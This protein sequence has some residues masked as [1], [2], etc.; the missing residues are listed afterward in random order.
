ML[1]HGQNSAY[2]TAFFILS[3]VSF[4]LGNSISGLPRSA[5]TIIAQRKCY[6]L[7]LTKERRVHAVPFQTLSS[8][9]K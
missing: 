3:D 7:T 2:S 1:C 6:P 4:Q 9:S 5:N 8:I